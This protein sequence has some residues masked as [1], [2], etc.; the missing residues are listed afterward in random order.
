MG[1]RRVSKD[2][3]NAQATLVE[4]AA[5]GF[6][7]SAAAAHL[8]SPPDHLFHFTDCAGLI[9]I[10]RTKTL[11][12]SLATS[13]NDRS[14]MRYVRDLLHELITSKEIDTKTLSL[15]SLDVALD[16]QRWRVYVVSLCRRPDTALQWLHYGRS[17]AGVAIGFKTS[18]IER[19]PFR[20]SQVL[21]D[22][23]RQVE[24]C[25][26]IVAAVDDALDK[27]LRTMLERRSV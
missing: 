9:G 10:L 3:V 23:A 20:L 21:Y 18:H 8:E 16:R 12:A 14:E 22:R 17:G 6:R 27:V 11:W 2:W 19:V 24:W 1:R 25:K 13:S 7:K 26:S 5:D 4:L 15:K